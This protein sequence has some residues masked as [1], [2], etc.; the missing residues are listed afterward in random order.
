MT[1][2]SLYTW[3]PVAGIAFCAVYW[4]LLELRTWRRRRR[5]RHVSPR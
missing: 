5:E 3:F 4:G 1:A 2:D